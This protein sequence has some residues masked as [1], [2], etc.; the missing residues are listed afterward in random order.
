MKTYTYTKVWLIDHK[1]VIAKTLIQAIAL[2]KSYMNGESYEPT[3]VEAISNN[4]VIK[5]F[6]AIVESTNDT[7]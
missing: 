7:D 3:K 4:A 1:L 2:M 6:D 5:D